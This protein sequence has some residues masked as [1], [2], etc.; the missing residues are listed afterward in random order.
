[1]RKLSYPIFVIL[2]VI[3]SLFIL[4]DDFLLAVNKASLYFNKSDTT[5]VTKIK[6]TKETELAG[7]IQ[8]PGA[9]RVFG[10][11][12][13]SNDKIKLS[14]DNIINLTNK[15]RKDNGD[16]QPLTENPKLDLSAEKKL[17]D[18]FNKQY[19]EHISPAKISVGD[20]GDQVGYEYILIGE[21][22]ALGNFK[23]DGALVDAWMASPGHRE[24]ILNKHYLDIGV[25]VG[26]GI[27]E[28]KSVWMAVQHFGTPKS[29][30]PTVDKVLY[31]VISLNQDKIKEMEQDLVTR[32][33]NIKKGI[34]YEGSTYF[35]QVDKYNSLLN[36]YN[37][38]IVETKNKVEEYNN[39]IKAFNLCLYQNE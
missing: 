39:Q 17:E 37:N 24:N 14:K 8:T 16:L 19:F 25:A 21:N 33:E 20:L 27:Y 15:A 1:M 38:L 22:L 18:M 7:K 34:I 4:K 31:G 10:M 30:C 23:D 35:E 11:Y 13:S 28:G 26:K 32:K 9:L 5:Q 29:I 36:L 12:L 3:V 6:D 2:F